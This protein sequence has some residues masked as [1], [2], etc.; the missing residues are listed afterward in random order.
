MMQHISKLLI[1]TGPTA[2]GKTD[3]ALK[4]A[5]QLNG[6]I[7]ACD[8]RQVYKGLDLGTGKLPGQEVKFS[9][10][11]KHWLIDGVKVWGYDLVE[12]TI[13]LTVKDYLDFVNPIIAQLQDD[14]KL[15]IVVG[16]TG[17]YLQGIVEGFDNISDIQDPLLRTSLESLSL[18][19]LQQ[20]LQTVD[21][22]VWQSLNQSDRQN[23]R[24]LI[25]KIELVM[26]PSIN[27]SD[28]HIS[29]YDVL[30]IGLTAPREILNQRIDQR[31]DQRIE[32]GLIKEAERLHK[33]G[34]SLSRMKE[35]GLEYGVLAALLS[36][37]IDLATFKLTL[38]NKI[39]QYAKR[40]MT[41][42]KRD[43]DINWFDI[44]IQNWSS[45]VEKTVLSWYNEDVNNKVLS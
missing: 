6:E 42:F 4:L 43:P 12:P 22:Q 37:Q 45:E 17:L 39:H 19:D 34:L 40:Q 27:T 41:W 44:T 24:R 31:L 33:Q 32:Q 20:R 1:I 21:N 5:K 30:K 8:S 13:R 35:L 11:D 29:T 16:G 10:H 23:P 9:R 18:N 26:Y 25:R 38:K 7:I 15:P 28:N 3:I 14:H 36:Q 2:T